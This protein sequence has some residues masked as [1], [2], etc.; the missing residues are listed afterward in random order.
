M[1]VKER[2]EVEEG[3]KFNESYEIKPA[4]QSGSYTV[5]G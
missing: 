3:N 4:S 5:E 1:N 2:L